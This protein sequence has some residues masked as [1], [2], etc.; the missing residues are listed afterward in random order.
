MKKLT[1]SL[2]LILSALS[3]ASFAA[4]PTVP[5][6]FVAGDVASA[7][8]VNENFA[9]IADAIST[10][11]TARITDSVAFQASIDAQSLKLTNLEK[12]GQTADIDCAADPVALKTA[13]NDGYSGVNILAGSC[14]ADF[15][16]NGRNFDITSDGL[17]SQ[18]LLTQGTYEFDL[19]LIASTVNITNVDVIG[20][21]V[22]VRNSLMLFTD[23]DL[24]C[25]AYKG[26]RPGFVAENSEIQLINANVSGC[27]SVALRY[28]STL[29]L[30]GKT[31]VSGGTYG[32]AIYAANDSHILAIGSVDL[33]SDIQILMDTTD[34]VAGE[35][36]PM[37]ISLRDSLLHLNDS[38]LTLHGSIY[39]SSSNMRISNINWLNDGSVR[40]KTIMP[41]FNSH[42]ELANVDLSDSDVGVF[43]SATLNM[44][45][46]DSFQ[47]SNLDLGFGAGSTGYI[48]TPIGGGLTSGNQF[49]AGENSSVSFDVDAAAFPDYVFDLDIASS[50][51]SAVYVKAASITGS[52]NCGNAN[53]IFF[54]DVQQC[55]DVAR[56]AD[57][58]Q[59][60]DVVLARVADI[61]QRLD[62][63]L[64]GKGI[65]VDCSA[66]PLALEGALNDGFNWI[67]VTAGSCSFTDG[68][69]WIENVTS[70]KV[71]IVGVG[72]AENI[73][74]PN[75]FTVAGH[76][77]LKLK[78]IV[79]EG[80]LSVD[81]NAS[82]TMY[83]SKLDCSTVS[84][85]P[86]WPGVHVTGRFEM[87]GS[88]IRGCPAI[89][90][91][92]DQASA[93]LWH[94]FGGFGLNTIS[95]GTYGPAV[96]LQGGYLQADE[97]IFINN[98][99]DN[100]TAIA[101][102]GGRMSMSHANLQGDIFLQDNAVF[103]WWENAGAGATWSPTDLGSKNLN[104]Q[105]GAVAT[106]TNI[107]FSGGS[108]NA[109]TQAILKLNGLTGDAIVMDSSNATIDM[110]GSTTTN[111]S[112][113]M[114]DN[115]VLKAR[116]VFDFALDVAKLS[117][118][119]IQNS[120]AGTLTCSDG[121]TI[122]VGGV[123][124][125]SD[126]VKKQ[127]VTDA[128][129]AE[130]TARDNAI[131]AAINVEV[132]NRDAA[133]TAAVDV[134]S[135][136]LTTNIT[137]NTTEV[138]NNYIALQSLTDRVSKVEGE[139]TNVD[140]SGD[141]QA[142]NTAVAEGFYDIYVAAGICLID[143]P[144]DAP[145]FWL[146][147]NGIDSGIKTPLGGLYF[148]GQ[149]VSLNRLIINGT[150]R[151]KD[152]ARLM[153]W[154]STIDC[155]INR[156]FDGSPGVSARSSSFVG[157]QNTTIKGCTA[158][159][160]TLGS[161]VNTVDSTFEHLASKEALY[162]GSN[163][164]FQG[165]NLTIT[166]SEDVSKPS[167][168]VIGIDNNSTAIIDN[169]YLSG[170]LSIMD[171]SSLRLIN[172]TIWTS[173][174]YE[175]HFIALYGNSAAG[176]W[177]VDLSDSS[178]RVH[179]G[180]YISIDVPLSTT[181]TNFNMEL[182]SNSTADINMVTTSSSVS[183]DSGAY[184]EIVGNSS[185]DVEIGRNSTFEKGSGLH[186]GLVTCLLGTL[187]PEGDVCLR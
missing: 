155:S 77:H 182:Q 135:T 106:F 40:K 8:K 139:W 79:I 14:E 53:Q 73:V 171:S 164:T 153:I 81:A 170:R 27:A 163:S 154:N 129:S 114:R 179:T 67:T 143:S 20:R 178:I 38:G 36:M 54:N 16:I 69:Y 45:S 103:R 104:M 159:H 138:A 68:R 109:A 57:I 140:C 56:V 148:D 131:A 72:G 146:S 120:G 89:W 34:L 41:H 23:S 62:G 101:M 21:I 9:S 75:G 102:T 111:S 113:V 17:S 110:D 12:Q 162:I 123:E 86:N 117:A 156:E 181:A 134:S 15:L 167:V 66:N 132:T 161:S 165:S 121:G 43:Q 64:S 169:S 151:A 88:E 33:V 168:N 59:S 11:V 112:I 145:Q 172:N 7:S 177:D 180:S 176:I 130:V 141:D 19:A 100:P 70:Q 124:Y 119:Q 50:M 85:F 83:Q 82:L 78:N 184:F 183:L 142:L 48:T 116:G 25:S 147:G 93:R 175:Q 186:T 42:L 126:I 31:S 1:L 29:R 97:T 137:N 149:N 90:I 133:I 107:D 6:T 13:Y 173:N 122:E 144:T 44:H 55:S 39:G 32:N 26:L 52:Y 49:W 105:S 22:V 98:P 127:E 96:N 185:I 157:L 87:F 76:S 84:T 80:G 61:D 51:G 3:S 10:E 71:N 47:I 136:S 125:C 166:R 65:D 158:V 37:A 2:A 160:A 91:D 28:D 128:I 118:A 24:D 60:V 99:G 92:G 108:V 35:N 94:D 95:S 30:R 46:M 174:N 187:A 74:V 18:T 63:V 58:D 4:V 115:A 152:H 5:N 150:L